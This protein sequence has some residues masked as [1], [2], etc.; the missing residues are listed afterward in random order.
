MTKRIQLSSIDQLEKLIGNWKYAL[1]IARVKW[2]DA[3]EKL[4]DAEDEITY[5][6]EQIRQAKMRLEWVK[7]RK[8]YKSD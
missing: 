6:K 5:I 8:G 1:E 3:S 4:V 2:S 7:K